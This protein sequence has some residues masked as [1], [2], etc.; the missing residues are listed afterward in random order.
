MTNKEIKISTE[1][2]FFPRE[3]Q[4][5]FAHIEMQIAKTF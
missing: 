2:L 4:D 3:Q 5:C 1:F